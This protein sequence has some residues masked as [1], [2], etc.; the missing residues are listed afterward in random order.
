MEEASNYVETYRRYGERVSEWV[1][2]RPVAMES[3]KAMLKKVGL[4][5]II[6]FS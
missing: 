1:T 4:S 3:S 2:G 6:K 5:R